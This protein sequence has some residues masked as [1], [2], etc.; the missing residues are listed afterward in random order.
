MMPSIRKLALLVND[1]KPEAQ[2]LAKIIKHSTEQLGISV[3]LLHAYPLIEGSLKGMDACCVIGGDGTILSVIKE[4]VEQK[5]PVFG[6]NQGRLGF[7]AT[8][9]P[10]E[11]LHRLP[12]IIKGEYQIYQRSLLQY[13]N[14]D[15]NICG[16]A[17][18]DCVIKNQSLIRLIELEVYFHDELVGRYACDGLIFA[19]STGSTAYNLSAGGPIVHPR[20]HV[21]VMTP[22]CP[23][24]LSNRSVILPPDSVLT[25][26]P[27]LQDSKIQITLDGA[28][29]FHAAG[30]FPAVISNSEKT[31][32]LLQPLDY[33]Y[34][35]VLRN[36]LKWS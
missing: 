26:K 34:F 15:G 11:A 7:L 10:D 1:H 13:V 16:L 18:N 33:N 35:R 3:T 31:L 5:V 14:A 17:L 24:A 30:S 23:H 22:I 12:S 36:K 32:T 20:N 9:S 8:F 6:V 19:T 27:V 2:S 21:I 4:A 28:H 25:I 29:H